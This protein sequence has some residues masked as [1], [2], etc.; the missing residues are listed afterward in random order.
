MSKWPPAATVYC[1]LL[2]LL[3][4]LCCA[5]GCCDGSMW[6]PCHFQLGARY[7]LMRISPA[8]LLYFAPNRCTFF[9]QLSQNLHHI[10]PTF[11]PPSCSSLPRIP[12]IFSSILRNNLHYIHPHM[13]PPI[14]VL[15]DFPRYEVHVENCTSACKRKRTQ[16][17]VQQKVQRGCKASSQRNC[18]HHR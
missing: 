1:T 12:A 9:L 16:V 18:G 5:A 13:F 4:L 15:I 14:L 3:L 10:H 7:P 2:L 17:K 11:D 6:V 8:I